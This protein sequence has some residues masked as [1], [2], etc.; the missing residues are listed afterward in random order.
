MGAHLEHIITKL[1]RDV[2]KGAGALAVKPTDDHFWCNNPKIII[3]LIHFILFQNSFEIGFFFWVW[4]SLWLCA[5]PLYIYIFTIKNATKFLYVLWNMLHRPHMDLT[6]ASWR[7]WATSSLNLFLGKSLGVEHGIKIYKKK[8][9]RRHFFSF[10]MF[11]HIYQLRKHSMIILVNLF[12][13]LEHD[14]NAQPFGWR[15]P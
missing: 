8:K 15:A 10:V 5:N 9:K 14:L 13:Y 7:K 12:L 4:V 2:E 6:R 1:A 11:K 3:Y